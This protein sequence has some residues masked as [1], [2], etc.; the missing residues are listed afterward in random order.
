MK[1]VRKQLLNSVL[2]D[3]HLRAITIVDIR[4]NLYFHCN[5]VS[6]KCVFL[7]ISPTASLVDTRTYER[8]LVGIIVAMVTLTVAML[9]GG[10]CILLRKHW[11]R[12]KKRVPLENAFENKIF[13]VIIL[14]NLT[15]KDRLPY[16]ILVFKLTDLP[17]PGSLCF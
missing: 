13:E 10:S 17:L 16:Y 8:Y 1:V 3:I 7:L 15:F 2:S 6:S 5:Q 9:V 11:H 12:R 4:L 14:I